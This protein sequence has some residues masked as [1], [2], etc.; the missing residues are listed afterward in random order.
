MSK[1]GVRNI[2]GYNV[3]IK[4]ARQSGE[5]L[6]RR[7]QTGFDP[8]SGKPI[9]ENQPVDPEAFTLYCCSR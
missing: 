6:V 8:D 4:E 5:L 2:D 3:R 7:V 1:L 9:F